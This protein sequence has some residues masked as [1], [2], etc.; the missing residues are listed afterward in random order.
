MCNCGLVWVIILTEIFSDIKKILPT[1]KIFLIFSDIKKKK[2]PYRDIFALPTWKK[3]S[4]LF[5]HIKSWLFTSSL[6]SSCIDFFSSQKYRVEFLELVGLEKISELFIPW[7][8][9]VCLIFPFRDTTMIMF[10][11]KHFF[12]CY[13]K[14]IFSQ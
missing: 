4:Y 3:K 2:N 7:L 12:C 10:N 9:L 14:I 11:F 8:L 13:L 1:W 5:N 6:W